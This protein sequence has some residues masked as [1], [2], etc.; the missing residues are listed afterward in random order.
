MTVEEAVELVIQA[1]P[2]VRAAR[3]SCSTWASGQ[4]RR[5]RSPDGEQL[6]S[7]DSSS[8]PA[9]GPARS[10]T[11]LFSD[12]EIGFQLADD[13]LRRRAA[14]TPISS[15]PSTPA[16]TIGSWSTLQALCDDMA[17]RRHVR[18]QHAGALDGGS[19]LAPRIA[20]AQLS[21]STPEASAQSA[22]ERRC[23][24]YLTQFFDPEPSSVAGLPLASWLQRQDHGEVVTGFPNC[25][26]RLSGL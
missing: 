5:R 19:D 25:R 12:F 23:N 22:E 24:L 18:S 4:D 16:S 11:G 15:A 10:F 2:S 21:V 20:T 14:L 6:E 1:G 8:T 26:W 17:A 13:Q 9:F 3:S 7:A